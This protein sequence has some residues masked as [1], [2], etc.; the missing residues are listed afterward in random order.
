MNRTRDLAADAIVGL[1]IFIVALWLLR[2][3]VGMFMWLAS[4]ISLVIVVIVL[5]GLARAVRGR[6]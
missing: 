1:T 2:R 6:R 3:F 5:L 4:L